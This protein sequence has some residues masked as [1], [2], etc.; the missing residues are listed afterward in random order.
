MIAPGFSTLPAALTARVPPGKGLVVFD[1]YCTLCSSSVR[2]LLH[3]DRHKKL[4]FS[5]GNELQIFDDG[6][7][8]T[9]IYYSR[10]IIFSRSNAVVAL[11]KDIG[12]FWKLMGSLIGIVP[13]N[14][15]DSIYRWVV[16]NRF[17]WF[18]KRS[19]CFLPGPENMHRF[20]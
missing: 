10:G 5:A 19:T 1:G 3:I 6:E 8:G 20:I 12:G 9:I 7:T 2:F 15:R 16:R 17:R 4:F 13:P 14:F 11:L 18:G